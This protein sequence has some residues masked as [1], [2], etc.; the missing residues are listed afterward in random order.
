M[1]QAYNCSPLSIPALNLSALSKAV[2][3]FPIDEEG[4]AG[5]KKGLLLPLYL[6]MVGLG[7][8]TGGLRVS[9][10][11][12]NPPPPP[13]KK[14]TQ[15]CRICLRDEKHKEAHTTREGEGNK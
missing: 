15:H 9:K 2:I 8:R 1:A 11:F 10:G 7:L 4:V 3:S 12:E 13:P 6:K 5:V 14:K